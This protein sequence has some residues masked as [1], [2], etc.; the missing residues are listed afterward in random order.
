MICL[1]SFEHEIG[2]DGSFLNLTNFSHEEFDHNLH[3]DHLERHGADRP[4][5]QAQKSLLTRAHLVFGYCMT[6]G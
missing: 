4:R 6:L 5:L 3:Q 2:D 1:T